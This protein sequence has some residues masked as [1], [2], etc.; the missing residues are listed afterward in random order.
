MFNLE[1]WLEQFNPTNPNNDRP[2]PDFS[3]PEWA[4]R[5]MHDVPRLARA[6]GQ[7]PPYGW[8]ESDWHQ[9]LR[10]TLLKRSQGKGKWDPARGRTTWAS[11]ATLVMQTRNINL[12]R[13][14][15]GEKA[16]LVMLCTS[17]MVESGYIE[18]YDG[19]GITIQNGVPK[20]QRAAKAA[21]QRQRRSEQQRA[22][23]AQAAALALD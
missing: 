3:Q 19:E 13:S 22:R 16:N 21:Q 2:S 12:R 10:E 8:D 17:G 7:L 5:L 9:E 11:W 4:R 15:V 23:R 1:S 14:T 20:W 18:N 6:A